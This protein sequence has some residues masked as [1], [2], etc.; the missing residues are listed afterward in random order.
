M[1][2]ENGPITI[3]LYPAGYYGIDPNVSL[4]YNPYTW[5]NVTSIMYIEQPQ[6]GTGFSQSGTIPMNETDVS[7]QFYIFLQNFYKIF[8]PSWQ[9]KQLYFF[10]ESYAGMFVPS[11]AHY[12]YQQ[13]RNIMKEHHHHMDSNKNQQQQSMIVV[14]LAGIALGNGWMDAQVQGPAVIDYAWWHGM[15]DTSTKRAMKNEWNNCKDGT[16]H[17]PSPFHT[18]TIPD[19][20]G[21][22]G[23]VLQ[24]AGMGIVDWGNPN[25][26][27]VTTWDP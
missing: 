24:A 9:N 22:M 21:I 15:I 13:N 1:L 25:A 5:T 6:G 18:F 14:P 20:C 8:D 16:K 11:I 12:I 26:Y 19:E 7:R 10:G 23:A 2:F 17:Q 4:Q 27:D 3:P